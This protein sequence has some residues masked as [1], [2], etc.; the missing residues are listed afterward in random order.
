MI[1]YLLVGM[2]CVEAYK[3]KNIKKYEQWLIFGDGKFLLNDLV[4]LKGKTLGC[5]CKP[6][7]CHGDILV[8][9][10]NNL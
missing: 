5:W 3:M 6:K 7:T 8:K 2:V 1:Y 4:E 9:L 10:A